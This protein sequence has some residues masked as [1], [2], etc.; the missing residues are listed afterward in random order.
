MLL[1]L[2]ALLSVTGAGALLTVGAGE[3]LTWLESGRTFSVGG[4]P[5]L[6]LL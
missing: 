2:L 6:L 3:L 1:P 4:R 5:P